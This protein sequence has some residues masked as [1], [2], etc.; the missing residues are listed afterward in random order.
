MTDPVVIPEK[1][2]LEVD[3]TAWS[4]KSALPDPSPSARVVA[5]F[6]LDGVASHVATPDHKPLVASLAS[7]AA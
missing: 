4:P 6:V 3:E 2:G 1:V 7:S 5:R